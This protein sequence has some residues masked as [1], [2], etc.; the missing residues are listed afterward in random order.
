MKTLLLTL[1]LLVVLLAT[2]LVS[3]SGGRR[4]RPGSRRGPGP[5]PRPRPGPSGPITILDCPP[6]CQLSEEVVGI[7]YPCDI[8]CLDKCSEVCPDDDDTACSVSWCPTPPRLELCEPDT[9]C[10]G[11]SGDCL[12]TATADNDQVFCDIKCSRSRL[13]ILDCPPRMSA[14]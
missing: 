3:S 10:D 13:T 9:D 5:R 11:C 1:I 6:E 12:R 4:Q 7:P 8:T 2:G 14:F